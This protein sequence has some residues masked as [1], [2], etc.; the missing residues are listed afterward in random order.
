MPSLRKYADPASRQRAYRLR[1]KDAVSL[2]PG[3]PLPAAILA[4]PSH[5]RW[6]K[7]QDKAKALLAEVASE[8]ESYRDDRS[9][10]WHESEKA[11]AF[12]EHLER[13]QEALQAIDAIA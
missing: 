9:D 3:I 4:M 6:K 12:E 11:I 7:M 5:P 2:G 13:V 1:L 10:Q 8:M